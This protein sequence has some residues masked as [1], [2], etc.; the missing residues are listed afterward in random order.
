MKHAACEE[1][2]CR[3]HALGD[4]HAFHK[5]SYHD[6]PA[7]AH[8]NNANVLT[9]GP[10]FLRFYPGW[11]QAP[12]NT[13]APILQTLQNKHGSCPGLGGHPNIRADPEPLTGDTRR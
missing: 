7:P 10:R 13:A 3:D 11:L 9:D 5:G 6:P 8:A 2:D 4:G 1:I 12:S